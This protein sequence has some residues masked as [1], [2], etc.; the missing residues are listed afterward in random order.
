M[1]TIELRKKLDVDLNGVA[2]F[3][4]RRHGVVAVPRVRRGTCGAG[5][6][7]GEESCSLGGSISL[8]WPAA[9]SFGSG[10]GPSQFASRQVLVLDDDVILKN[11]K[12]VP[13]RPAAVALALTCSGLPPARRFF[14][15]RAVAAA[16]L[17]RPNPATLAL[18]ASLDDARVLVD[19]G[20]RECVSAYVRHGDKAIEMKLVPFRAYGSAAVRLFELNNLSAA[21]AVPRTLV[22]GTEDH[23]VLAEAAT[24]ATKNH[25]RVLVSNLT[26]TILSDKL[27][28]V[29]PHTLGAPP[30]LPLL[31]LT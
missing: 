14:W 19:G 24:W 11:H 8:A 21:S 12:I 23:T 27:S 13:S 30:S 16:Y 10:S 28:A 22:L 5:N 6:G 1:Q 18:L 25:V 31:D 2:L 29:N 7:E 17:L 3:A 15:W 4:T 26:R 9:S 20:G